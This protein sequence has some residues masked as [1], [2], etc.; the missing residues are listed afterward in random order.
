MTTVVA[1]AADYKEG[2]DYVTV[3]GIPEPSKPMLRE[4]FSY[5]CPHCYHEDPVIQKLVSLLKGKVA[6]ERTPVGAHRPSWIL[7]Q[8]A[9]YLAQ[10]FK[11]TE[12]VHSKIFELIHEQHKP[13][14]TDADLKAFFE[15]QGI[16]K[17]VLDKNIGSADAKL[18][19]EN[20]ETQTQLSKIRGVPSLLVNGKYLIKTH[21]SD[22]E[23][24]AKLIEY[25]ANKAD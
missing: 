10:K 3:E 7:S 12:Q 8:E 14:N 9:Y 4:F 13:F 22:A 23:E 6:F 17:D 20:Y 2:Q 11:I 24:L 5:N 19:M 21:M 16:D 18:A 1:K 25:L 15:S